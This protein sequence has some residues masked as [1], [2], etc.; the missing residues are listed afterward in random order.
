MRRVAVL[1]FVSVAAAAVVTLIGCATDNGAASPPDTVPSSSGE[2]P[3]EDARPAFDASIPS[4]P[5]GGTS[6]DAGS[7]SDAGKDAGACSD[8]DDPGGTENVAKVL[9]PTDDCDNDY[10]TVD[11]VL[12]SE[13]DVDMYALS[14][15]DKTFCSLDTDFEAKTQGMQLCVFLRCKNST[16][17]AVTGCAQGAEATNEL[18]R[19]GCCTSGPGHAIPSWDCSG[20]SDDDSADIS[21]EV[22]ADSALSCRPYTFTYRF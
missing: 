1:R 20:F 13:A 4:D 22:K 9:A 7:S 14:A 11:G 21:I 19:K 5:D 3:P 17:D 12:I 10:K 2:K 8:P 16:V 18:G 15:T 6:S